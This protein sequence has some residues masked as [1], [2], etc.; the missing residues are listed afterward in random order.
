MDLDLAESSLSLSTDM[1]LVLVLVGFTM[2]MFVWEKLRPDVTAMLVLMLLGLTGLV[3]S[4]QIFDGFAGSAV[5]SIIATMVL[6]AGLDRTGL[7]NRIAGWLLRRA[8][9]VEERLILYATASAGLISASMQNPSVMALFLPVASRLSARS[10][11]PVARLLMPIAMCVMLGGTLTMVGNSPQIMLNDLLA[12]ANHNLP[13]GVATLEALPMFAP[14]PVGI[15]LLA[16]GLLYF[17]LFGQRLLG[18]RADK[19]VT[20]ARTESYFARTYGIAGEVFELTVTAES[21]L[22]GMSIGEAE[23]Q[24]GAPLLLALKSGNES[25]LAPPSDQMIWV[26]SVLGVMGPREQVTDYAQNNL[27]RLQSR[28]RHFGDLFN[29]SRA[30]ISEAVIPPTSSFIDHAV[31]DLQLRRRFGISVLAVYRDGEVHREGHRSLA[32][33]AGDMLVFHSIWRDLAKAAAKRDFVV[34]TD[35][36]KDEQR[37]HKLWIATTIFV[38]A[39][40]LA[41]SRQIAVPV[42]LM[43]GA[44]AMVLSGVLN[45]DEAYRSINWKTVFLMAGLIPLGWAVESSGLAAYLAQGLLTRIGEWPTL[46]PQALLAVSTVLLGLVVGHVGAT[47]IMVPIAINVAISIGGSPLAFALT[48]ALSASNNLISTS[49]PVLAM[50]SGPG[51]YHTR[52]WMRVGLPLALMHLTVVLV[53]VNIF[54]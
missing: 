33:R 17:R 50:V 2:V 7:M 32:L 21:P 30:G 13:S 11:V 53:V 29:P 24:V 41:L 34:V 15:V 12:Q 1:V 45:M 25:R 36:P 9:G 54:Y 14:T 38:F 28:L 22:V 26:G 47:A 19:G 20:P 3:S 5:V 23:T 31:G 40:A 35:F 37:P 42:A 27:L 39:L 6:G 43:A 46:L 44:M 48:M 49:N 8:Q 51:G 52:D 18:G 16:G 10:G 4:D